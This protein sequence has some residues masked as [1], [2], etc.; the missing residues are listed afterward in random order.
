MWYHA[1]STNCV[2]LSKEEQCSLVCR[3]FLKLCFNCIKKRLQKQRLTILHTFS[4]VDAVSKFC[5]FP[6]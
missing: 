4:E 1:V 6:L 2:M 3:F 5:S